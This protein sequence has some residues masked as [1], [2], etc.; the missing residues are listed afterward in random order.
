MEPRHQK[1]DGKDSRSS[2]RI[3]SGTWGLGKGEGKEIRGE[4]VGD[5][6]GENKR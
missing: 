2:L 5:P 6:V 1:G 4:L 3:I